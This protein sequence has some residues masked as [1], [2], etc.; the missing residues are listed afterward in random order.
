MN[1]NCIVSRD[2]KLSEPTKKIFLSAPLAYNNALAHSMRVNVYNDDGTAADLSGVGVTGVFLRADNKTVNPINGTTVESASGVKNI[3]EIILPASCYIVPGRYTFTMNL[4][5]NGSTR[6]V[7]WVEGHVERNTSEEIID[8]GTP[9]GNIEQAIGSAN[10]AASAANAAASDANAAAETA[11]Q[12]AAAAQEVADNVEGEVDEL[13]SALNE[14]KDGFANLNIFGTAE[15]LYEDG[16]A[17]IYDGHISSKQPLVGL[18]AYLLPVD[19]TSV[20]SFVGCRFAFLLESDKYTAIGSLL[21]NVTQVNSTGASYICF[22]VNYQTYP[23]NDYIVS[24]GDTLQTGFVLPDWFNA[25]EAEKLD[26]D[27]GQANAGKALIVGNNG[28]V[29]PA[30]VDIGVASVNGETGEVT[31]RAGDLEYNPNDTNPDGSI[32][33]ALGTKIDKNGTGQVKPKNI[34]GVTVTGG[35]ILDD[36]ERLYCSQSVYVGGGGYVDIYNSKALISYNDVFCSFL[37]PVKPNTHYTANNFIRFAVLLKNFASEGTS[38]VYYSTVVGSALENISSF[39]TGEADHII[40]SWNYSTYPINTFV[41][42]EGNTPT[43]DV[44]ITLPDWWT[45]G[46]VKPK[47]ISTTGNLSDGTFLA[48]IG[49]KQNLRKGE[50]YVF[51]GDLT[52]M[53]ELRFG[54]TIANSFSESTLIFNEFTIDSTYIT[55][56]TRST[57][58]NYTYQYTHGLTFAN[59]IQLIFEYL[60]EG[61]A[62]ITLISNGMMFSQTLPFVKRTI[63][64][65]VVLSVGSTLTNCKLTWIPIDIDKDIWMFGDSYF[66]YSSDRWTYY[67]QQYGYAQNALIDG[68]PGEGSVNARNS[69]LTLIQFG[70]PKY[71][72]WCMGMND[73]SDT[74]ANTPS[75]DWTIRRDEMLAICNKNG[76]TPIFATIPNVPSILHTGKNA[77]IKAS[78]YRYIDFA[79]AVG[80]ESAGSTWYS[81]MLSSDNVHPSESGAKALF[82]RALVDF[83]EIM[84]DE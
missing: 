2:I 35:N 62:K 15:L 4:T 73:G 59:N 30:E 9:V 18:N 31:L 45:C 10:S 51:S 53:S 78:G 66:A 77:W 42:S 28:I 20:Y 22:T 27:Q 56:K 3:A 39:D 37:I 32:G 82:A 76:I 68:W 63:S 24:K 74:D 80:A 61:N 46:I 58:E 55:Y 64:Q 84:I 72:V 52:T 6:T 69:L 75:S 70:T 65:V 71:I 54:F 29:T 5:A 38:P 16:Y 44:E 40:V 34:E 50:R 83:P 25:A 81:G 36:A 12:A 41:I 14:Y 13:R 79:A 67:M 60:D 26:K 21:Q 7:L 43:T 49:Y 57:N 23:L 48:L 19:G 1:V 47:Y 8:P 11:T 33:A 17:M